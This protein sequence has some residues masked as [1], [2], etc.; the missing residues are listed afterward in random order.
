MVLSNPTAER[1]N[2]AALARLIAGTAMAATIPMMATAISNSMR[3]NPSARPT[4]L[5]GL[6]V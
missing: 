4:A 6:I 5:R 3:M 1:S 2:A